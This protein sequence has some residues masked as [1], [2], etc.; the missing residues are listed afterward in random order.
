M[1]YHV[2]DKTALARTDELGDFFREVED[3]F[4]I[5]WSH[6]NRLGKNIKHDRDQGTSYSADA[7]AEIAELLPEAED[8]AAYYRGLLTDLPESAPEDDRKLLGTIAYYWN[9]IAHN[10]RSMANR[11]WLATVT[12]LTMND[13]PFL[14]DPELN[15]NLNY[16]GNGRLADAFYKTNPDAPKAANL[17]SNTY[18]FDADPDCKHVNDKNKSSGVGC[19]K[20]RG[21]FCF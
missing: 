1:F 5:S 14:L 13:L 3:E 16:M 7:A 20:C 11:Y 9:G 17:L 8:Q 19:S 12:E 15:T 2:Q 18:L 21:W 4:E 6:L 10:Y